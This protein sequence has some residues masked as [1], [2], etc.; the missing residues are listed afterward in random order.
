MSPAVDPAAPPRP[1]AGLRAGLLAAALVAATA[2]PAPAV[3][4][5]FDARWQEAP[6][7]PFGGD[8]WRRAGD[9]LSVGTDGAEGP[10]WRRLPETLW[11][12]R[13]ASWRWGVARRTPGGEASEGGAR[14]LAIRFVFAPREAARRLEDA[15]PRRV[16]GHEA[17]RALVYVWGGAGRP[18]AIALAEDGRSAVVTRRQGGTGAASEAVDLAAD[19][20]RAFDAAPP[21]LVALAISADAAGAGGPIEAA[22]ADLVLD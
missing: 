19:Y 5:L 13:R 6:W 7:L 2:A 21:A 10:V 20:A 15:S 22:V 3:T 4:I 18:G 1:R 9:R 11:D 14:T 17:A 16:A 8:P 12:V